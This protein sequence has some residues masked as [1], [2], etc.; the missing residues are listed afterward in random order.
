MDTEDESMMP[1]R[2]GVPELPP[3][4][5]EGRR[6]EPLMD[7]VPGESGPRT[8]LMAIHDAASGALIRVVRIYAV[9]VNPELEA[10]VQ[11]VFFTRFELQA[12]QRRLLIENEHGGRYFYELDTGTVHCAG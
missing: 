12:D 10:D 5:F 11:D 2:I 8:G 6:Y 3:V 4:V 9:A 7:G 1:S